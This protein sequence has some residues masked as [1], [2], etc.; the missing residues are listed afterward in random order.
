MVPT[1]RFTFAEL[2]MDG[3]KYLHQDGV[4]YIIRDE[5]KKAP[6]GVTWSVEMWKGRKAPARIQKAFRAAWD[7]AVDCDNCGIKT[8]ANNDMG[9]CDYCNC[10]QHIREIIHKPSASEHL[11]VQAHEETVQTEENEE[12]VES[13]ESEES[14][15]I[16]TIAES[17]KST[18][19]LE[20]IAHII[21]QIIKF[22]ALIAFMNFVNT[23]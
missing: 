3:V 19:V 14:Q 8:N 13:V 1:I 2:W 7:V 5:P 12:S 11:I 16:V 17:K 6:K 4:V 10:A 21:F 20:F 9:L 22:V 23:I 18:S 15:E